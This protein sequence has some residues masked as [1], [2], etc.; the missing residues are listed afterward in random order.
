MSVATY[1]GPIVDP[2]YLN[3]SEDPITLSR[4]DQWSDIPYPG[5]FP[6]VLDP[7]IR[8]VR[9]KKVLIDGGSALNLLFVGALTELG[10]T[11]DD[12]VPVDSPFWGIVP[13]RASQPLGQITLH[14]LVWHCR[15]L[16]Y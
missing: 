9:F 3:G 2:K 14:I 6:L 16:L 7:T 8:N 1:D 5:C 11:K 13:G 4:A 15:P 10:L 12:L